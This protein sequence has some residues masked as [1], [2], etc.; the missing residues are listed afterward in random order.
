MIFVVVAFLMNSCLCHARLTIHY[1]TNLKISS[2]WTRIV[3]KK[4]RIPPTK[5]NDC[6]LVSTKK[7]LT[8]KMRTKKIKKTNNWMKKTT[9][10]KVRTQ[11]KKRIDKKKLI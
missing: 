11:M 6:Y 1:I 4:R 9:L 7:R 3:R 5:L 10:R 8:K 2:T